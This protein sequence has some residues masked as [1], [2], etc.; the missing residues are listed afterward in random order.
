MMIPVGILLALLADLT[1]QAGRGKP[2]L[3]VLVMLT[4]GLILAFLLIVT[5]DE[6]L[7]L[8]HL[9]AVLAGC[10]LYLTGLRRIFVFLN[11][12]IK[13]MNHENMTGFRRKKEKKAE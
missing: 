1:G 6:R 10:V 3:D 9:L 11:S 7:R 5:G 12:R 4:C 2:V 8:Y 13:Q